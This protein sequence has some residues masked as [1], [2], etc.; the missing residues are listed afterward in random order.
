MIIA[1]LAN[2]EN[3]LF[4][5]LPDDDWG[6]VCGADEAGRGPLAGPVTAAAV[7]LPKDF[8][9]DM[10]NDSKA[11]SEKEREAAEAV[12][13]EKAIAWAVVSLSHKVIDRINI[14]QASLE[15]MRMAYLKISACTPVDT[16]LVDGNKKPDVPV[17]TIAI[18]KGDSKI[19]EIMAASILA[20]T[21]RDRIMMLCDRKWPVYGYAK[22]KGYPT[23]EHRNAIAKYG[24][25]PIERLSFHVKEDELTQDLF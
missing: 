7:V 22:H 14:L 24:P 4:D 17:R 2:M 1:S 18:V 10:L 25:S 12:I 11:M 5:T 6:I 20:K 19:P 9:V 23:K 15:A 21:E 16:F 13:K 3:G 8:P